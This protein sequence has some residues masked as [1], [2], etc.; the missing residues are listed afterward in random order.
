MPVAI[1]MCSTALVYTFGH[2]HALWS[3]GL[4][5]ML[6]FA[7][8]CVARDNHRFFAGFMVGWFPLYA[9]LKVAE[10][11]RHPSDAGYSHNCPGQR[12]HMVSIL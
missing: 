2:H 10:I 1:I 5:G 7:G 9:K 4:P 12:A 3:S 8:N 11:Y 6:L